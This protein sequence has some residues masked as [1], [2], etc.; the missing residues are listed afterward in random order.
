MAVKY[1]NEYNFSYDSIIIARFDLGTRGKTTPQK[2]YA[3]DF[4]FIENSDMTN[5]HFAF[6][7]QFNHGLPDHWFYGNSNVMQKVG[8]LYYDVIKYYQIDSDYVQNV[9][10]GWFDSNAN[11]EFSN[12]MFKS[13]NEKTK[14]LVKWAKWHCIDNHKTYKWHLLKVNKIPFQTVDI[15]INY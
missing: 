15:T 6:W 14:N 8:D 5:L 10:N 7:D 12:E 4:N 1:S 11:D 13:E 9:T 3:T 2:Y